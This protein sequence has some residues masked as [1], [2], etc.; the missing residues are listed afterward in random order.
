MDQ[1][2]RGAIGLVLA[3]LSFWCIPAITGGEAMAD[4]D[5]SQ[6][7]LGTLKVYA[8]SPQV[9]DPKWEGIRLNAPSQQ[10]IGLPF[11]VCAYAR[12]MAPAPFKGSSRPPGTR[13]IEFKRLGSEDVVRAELKPIPEPTPEPYRPPE[14]VFGDPPLPTQPFLMGYNEYFNFDGCETLPRSLVP[15][16][17]EVR[18]QIGKV[19]SD[20]VQVEFVPQPEWNGLVWQDCEDRM[21]ATHVAELRL[22][23]VSTPKVLSPNKREVVIT[24]QLEKALRGEFIEQPG[25]SFQ[26]TG[27]LYTGAIRSLPVEAVDCLWLNDGPMVGTVYTLF[28]KTTEKTFSIKTALENFRATGIELTDLAERREGILWILDLTARKASRGQWVTD[29]RPGPIARTLRV[30]MFY[31]GDPTAYMT[32]E[33]IPQILL[34]QVIKNQK[35]LEIQVSRGMTSLKYLI[36]DSNWTAGGTE[37]LVMKPGLLAEWLVDLRP[38]FAWKD[39]ITPYVIKTRFHGFKDK[40]QSR[41]T[42]RGTLSFPEL[43]VKW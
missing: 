41:E 10:M 1:N 29:V 8:C 7:Q 35:M 21:Q 38:A 31:N 19:T 28:R 9:F 18:V 20:P 37:D 42:F 30:R 33:K 34:P 6:V 11:P 17:Y 32:A 40:S 5:F 24:L 26:F 2:A 39:P 16:V 43:K 4:K 27:K 14:M 15:G 25:Q 23:A 22:I 3:V 12:F 36:P 13:Q